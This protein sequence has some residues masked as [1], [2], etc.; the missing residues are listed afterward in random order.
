M[1]MSGEYMCQ[2]GDSAFSDP[3]YL[4]IY[5]DWLL[6]QPSL[7]IIKEGE[8]LVLSCHGWKNRTVYKVTYYH[9]NKALKYWYENHKYYISY[10]TVQNRGYYY[11]TGILWRIPYTSKPLYIDFKGTLSYLQFLFPLVTGIL[12]TVDTTLL[13]L[14][15]KQL[16]NL[17][18][19]KK[20]LAPKSPPR[21]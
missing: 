4:G 5:S 21:D 2:N 1:N 18:E 7:A 17:S 9:N 15:K 13:V 8:P 19:K 3:V 6:L 12:F 16:H 14:T 11:C 10:A 20:V